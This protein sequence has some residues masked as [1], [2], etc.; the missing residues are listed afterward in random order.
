MSSNLHSVETPGKP[1]EAPYARVSSLEDPCM[2]ESNYGKA[3]PTRI[4]MTSTGMQTTTVHVANTQ[5]T[6][7]VNVSEADSGKYQGKE[8]SRG[9]RKLFK[10]GKNSAASERY[11]ESD[12]ATLD[13]SVVDDNALNGSSS[14]GNLVSHLDGKKDLDDFYIRFCSHGHR[15]LYIIYEL[16][17]LE[18]TRCF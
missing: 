2:T 3:P 14:E 16:L 8:P 11:V 6:G 4:E 13:G 17:V 15:I 12:K 18:S 9:F 5:R 7:L 1:Y 10:F